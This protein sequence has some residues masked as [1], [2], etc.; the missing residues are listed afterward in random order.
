M[1]CFFLYEV[2]FQC[3]SHLTCTL[4]FEFHSLDIKCRALVAEIM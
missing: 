2:F 1:F 4:K 3:V